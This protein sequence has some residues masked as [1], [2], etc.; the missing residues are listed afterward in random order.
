MDPIDRN[1]LS[2]SEAPTTRPRI[3][4]AFRRKRWAEEAAW[5]LVGANLIAWEDRQDVEE[6]LRILAA[7][8]N[9]VPILDDVALPPWANGSDRLDAI[10]ETA[11]TIHGEAP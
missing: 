8:Y 4:T 5:T 1:A 7:P 2:L 11:H 6:M 10:G 3:R 9:A